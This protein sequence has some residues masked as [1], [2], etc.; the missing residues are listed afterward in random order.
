MGMSKSLQTVATLLWIWGTIGAIE[1]YTYS[2]WTPTEQTIQVIIKNT[3]WWVA[4]VLCRDE[5]KEVVYESWYK[6]P[7]TVTTNSLQPSWIYSPEGGNAQYVGK[8]A[9]STWEPL[10][11]KR[12]QIYTG[13]RNVVKSYT[14]PTTQGYKYVEFEHNGEIIQRY[15]AKNPTDIEVI[16]QKWPDYRTFLEQCKNIHTD[17]K[18]D[19]FET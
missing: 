12:I 9:N 15:L 8:N 2:I 13:D 10:M 5:K 7:Q 19:M 1:S 16:T 11:W 17:G 3:Q 6:F 14:F 18:P 4:Y